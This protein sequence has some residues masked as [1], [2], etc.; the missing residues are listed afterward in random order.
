M[1]VWAF[2]FMENLLSCGPGLFWL[3]FPDVGIC[4]TSHRPDECY[5]RHSPKRAPGDKPSLSEK[6]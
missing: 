5:I 1:A 2:V 3:H 6:D 4:R